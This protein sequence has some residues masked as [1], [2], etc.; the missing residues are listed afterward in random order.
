[1]SIDW[2]ASWAEIGVQDR[3]RGSSG[4]VVVEIRVGL[5]FL[6]SPLRETVTWPGVIKPVFPDNY[7]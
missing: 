1:M 4:E 3:I 6:V 5:L 7:L 2:T